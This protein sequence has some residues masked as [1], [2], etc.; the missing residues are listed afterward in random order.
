MK[1]KAL[2]II[3]FLLLGQPCF[4]ATRNKTATTFHKISHLISKKNLKHAY[5]VAHEH[6]QSLS[7]IP[8]FYRVYAKLA[9]Q[10]Q[11]YQ[12]AVNAC[13]KA[14]NSEADSQLQFDCGIA[15]LQ[16]KDYTKAKRALLRAK[17]LNP[18]YRDSVQG[19]LALINSHQLVAQVS[20]QPK[21]KKVALKKSQPKKSKPVKDNDYVI[22]KKMKEWVAM[23][24]YHRAYFLG[25]D[26]ER[27][28]DNSIEFNYYYGVAA[29]KQGDKA[30]A[31]REFSAMIYKGNKILAANPSRQQKRTLLA[32]YMTAKQYRNADKLIKTMSALSD[33]DY[34]YHYYVYSLAQRFKKTTLAE[35]EKR[36]TVD[37]LNKLI[38]D[39]PTR[40]NRFRGLE[41]YSR[42][43]LYQKAYE[44]GKAIWEHD[45]KNDTA[46]PY[47]YRVDYNLRY[48]KS[49]YE[50][51]D[52]T[53]AVHAFERILI[54]H[55]NNH[56]ARYYYAKAL[57][58]M[59]RHQEARRE[60]MTLAKVQQ[61][62]VVASNV[63]NL[64]EK[65]DA[66]APKR[67]PTLSANFTVKSGY[68]SNVNTA[69]DED[70]ISF[71]LPGGSILV[72]PL[73]DESRQQ[74]S[75]FTHGTATV[76]G[77]IPYG[78]TGTAFGQVSV[79][80]LLNYGA[81]QFNT[82]TFNFAVGTVYRFGKDG[83]Y[84]ISLPLQAQHLILDGRSFVD[85]IVGVG[86]ISRIMD[87]QNKL[88]VYFEHDSLSFPQDRTRNVNVNIGGVS[89]TH[90]FPALKT[91]L[92]TKVYYGVQSPYS[93]ASIDEKLGRK[94]YGI[95]LQAQWRG[96][97][98]FM[99]FVGL[100]LQRSIHSAVEVPF[101]DKNRDEFYIDAN[102][103]VNYRLNKKWLLTAEYRFTK[104]NSNIPLFE[105]N[106]NLIQL[107]ASYQLGS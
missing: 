17:A 9:L 2:F 75:A 56:D 85:A 42:L 69:T 68:D 39:S 12:Q 106:K 97:S 20:H 29:L 77:T 23:G 40:I 66:S 100:V 24:S 76:T 28:G 57:F 34:L 99:P 31:D 4:A 32:M 67:K 105:Y 18:R 26:N 36:K 72:T 41:Y 16:L 61:P 58:A 83:R 92:V 80:G 43:G 89:W 74:D 95:N 30:V 86:E 70:T 52:Y 107:G 46:D 101:S 84:E 49:A 25:K 51:K 27:L 3:V 63:K 94:L 11:H 48:G 50:V 103:G 64:L 73:D 45:F 7:K 104:N 65:I 33:K 15:Y 96:S 44:Q 19:V 6:E 59:G 10:T 22:I 81:S 62:I 21:T 55:P 13:D 87:E 35:H 71:V 88:G 90:I 102:L 91:W 60:L 8:G 47:Y 78:K 54:R 53:A 93:V 1:R 79:N 82:Q 38:A 37:A 14:K 5:Q 98:K